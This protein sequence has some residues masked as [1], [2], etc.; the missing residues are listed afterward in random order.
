MG[1]MTLQSPKHALA[2]EDVVITLDMRLGVVA[3]WPAEEVQSPLLDI[4]DGRKLL[5]G[6]KDGRLAGM[7]K[8]LSVCLLGV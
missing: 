8:L 5:A 4:Y 2:F 1:R 3:Y 7:F 6:T